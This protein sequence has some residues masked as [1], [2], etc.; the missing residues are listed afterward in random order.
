MVHSGYGYDDFSDKYMNRI[1]HEG[2]DAILVYVEGI[3]RTQVGY[4]DFNALIGRAAKYGLDVYAYSVMISK[5]HPENPGAYEFYE[6]L[7]GE[8]F[9]QCPGFKGVMFVG[10]SIGF[11]SHDERA[12]FSAYDS[13]S[14]PHGKPLTGYWPCRDYPQ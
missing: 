12:E 13:K 9:K 2:R 1:A 6:G 4:L 10:E 11:P 14:I 3:N 7:Y 8:L 5:M